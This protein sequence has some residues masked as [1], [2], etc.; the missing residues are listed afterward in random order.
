MKNLLICAIL[1]SIFFVIGCGGSTDFSGE[2]SMA[3]DKKAAVSDEMGF[4]EGSVEKNESE[5]KSSGISE[6]FFG[7]FE[8][9]KNRYLE[10]N[11]QISGRSDDLAVS[12]LM[13]LSLIKEYGFIRSVSTNVKGDRPRVS[14]DFY[15]KTENLTEVLK[16]MQQ[17]AI[18]ES[19]QVTSKDY[20]ADIVRNRI[21]ARREAYRIA[22][23][24]RSS[25]VFSYSQKN[26][27]NVEDA[28]SNAEDRLDQSEFEKWSI[29]DK[30]SWA[31][32]S[33]SLEGPFKGKAVKIPKYKNALIVLAQFFVDL[34]YIFIILIPLWV[35]II[36]VYIKRKWFAK[37]FLSKV[38]K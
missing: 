20:T 34:G 31:K 33:F 6:P 2:E 37:V 38:K 10:Y 19:E 29:N 24:E 11:V 22:R 3:Q 35:F 15:I 32:V 28:L 18:L 13:L 25:K 17:F 8:T 7:D 36:F 12:R 23:R 30:I 1:F 4:F 27:K 21:S 14:A 16:K 9:A 5:N 26:W